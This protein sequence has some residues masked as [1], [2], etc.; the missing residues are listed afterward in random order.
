[1]S[2]T[3]YMY[4]CMYIHVHVVVYI[5]VHCQYAKLLC[6]IVGIFICRTFLSTY[7]VG[8]HFSIVRRTYVY[9]YMYMHVY[10][11]MQKYMRTLRCNPEWVESGNVTTVVDFRHAQQVR[12]RIGVIRFHR[13]WQLRG[14]SD[15]NTRSRVDWASLEVAP[16]IAQVSSQSTLCQAWSSK[17]SCSLK[18]VLVL[19]MNM[20]N[21][22]MCLCTYDCTC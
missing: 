19:W 7:R 18:H 8:I 4:V 13:S 9:M 21:M 16:P 3:G 22:Y 10:T 2:G 14:C 1:M 6:R 12:A 15:K 5:H 11:R 17:D 20:H